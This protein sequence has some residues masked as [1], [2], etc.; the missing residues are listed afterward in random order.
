VKNKSIGSLIVL[1]IL[2]P[3]CGGGG[4]GGGTPRPPVVAKWQTQQRSPTSSDL[5]AVM[6]N[7]PLNG[8]I[9]GRDGTI[10]RTADGGQ[11]WTQQEFI[12][13]N[14]TGDILAMSAFGTTITAAGKDAVAG[15][16]VW[17]GRNSVSWVTPDAPGVGTAGMEL[18]D[19]NVSDPGSGNVPGTW[20]AIR[21]DG[22]V[23]YSFNGTPG[24]FTAKYFPPAPPPFTKPTH[25]VD[26]TQANSIAFVG[27]SGFGLI[28]GIDNGYAGHALIPGDPTAMPPIPD[29]PADPGHGPQGQIARTD[30]F[31]VTWLRQTLLPS[32]SIPKV[33][34]KIHLTRTSTNLARAYACGDDFSDHGVVFSSSPA[35]PDQ[36]DLLTG[37]N[38]PTTAPPFRALDFPVDDEVGW[39][40]GD[41]GTIYKITAVV[42]VS[43]S[44]PVRNYDYTWTLQG[45]GVTP[46]DLY[47]VSFGDETTGYAVGDNGTVLKTTNG[48]TTWVVI[49]KGAVNN[50]NAAAFTDDGVNGIAV[51]DGGAVYRTLN[52]GTT[53]TTMGAP[54]GANNLFG[55]SIPRGAPTTA[56]LCGAGGRLM[57]NTDVWGVGTWQ[58]AAG[59]TDNADT[60]EAVLFPIGSDRGVCVGSTVAG[61]KILR[62][63]DG[64]NWS[65]ATL[66]TTP[67]SSSYKA[68][69]CNFTGTEVY[70]A[71]GTNGAVSVSQDLANG[72]IT[73]VDSPSP[74]GGSLALST[75][76]F[77]SGPTFTAFAGATNNTNVYRLASG[78]AAWASAGS[79]FGAANPTKLAYQSDQTLIC[80][81]SDGKIFTT[82]NGGGSWTPSYAHTKD[83]ARGVWLSPT[84]PGLGYV[85]CNNGTIL[86]TTTGGQ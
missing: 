6:F 85:V 38:M 71:G 68:L 51:G 59:G 53:W 22:E 9:A 69:S 1:A 84:V 13:A 74:P 49:S 79:P 47:S 80:V 14:R 45:V 7:D 33:V 37:V 62:T 72:W 11:T 5:R 4:S 35:V 86:R 50:F 24:N 58:Q 76:A 15:G 48:G 55:A 28:A 63:I 23:Y 20:W 36:W 61:R 56:F 81:A 64:T 70:A 2:A 32:A 44:P 77:P 82:S 25:P 39:V 8:M 46:E 67:A 65:G 73:W 52:S 17:E 31:G 78:A 54:A 12:P 42:T 34:R 29:I 27:T 57:R 66:P 41:N 60:Y 21:N 3:S 26:W 19:V 18:R 40:V 10:F 16:R 83:L 75:V 30:N 43:G